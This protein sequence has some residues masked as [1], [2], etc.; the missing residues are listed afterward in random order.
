MA[1]WIVAFDDAATGEVLVSLDD[2]R[3]ADRSDRLYAIPVG[4]FSGLLSLFAFRAGFKVRREQEAAARTDES[5]AGPPAGA[6]S[7]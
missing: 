5:G 2:A 1:H 4:L 3:A 7:A 6:G